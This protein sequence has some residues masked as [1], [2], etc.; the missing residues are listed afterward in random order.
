MKD[1]ALVLVAYHRASS[2]HAYGVIRCV[3]ENRAKRASERVSD[4]SIFCYC[5]KKVTQKKPP[6][7]GLS[8]FNFPI[9][10]RDLRVAA[11]I[12]PRA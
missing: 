11:L 4:V 7:V 1:L 6:S 3:S 5:P 2:G 10:R 8:G 12:T 9:T